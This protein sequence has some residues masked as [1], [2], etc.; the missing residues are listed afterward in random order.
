MSQRRTEIRAWKK[1]GDLG[2]RGKSLDE[3]AGISGMTAW[4]ICRGPGKQS[5]VELR[6]S[7]CR[8]D[9][10]ANGGEVEMILCNRIAGDVG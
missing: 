8:N 2:I 9:L 10:W 3:T 5:L 6:G 4:W 7:E 1:C